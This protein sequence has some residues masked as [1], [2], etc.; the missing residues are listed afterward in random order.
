M[1]DILSAALSR[2]AG[3]VVEGPVRAIV[4]EILQDRGYASPAE[5][6]ALREELAELRQ[7]LEKLTS[8]VGDLRAEAQALR[9]QA[10][11]LAAAPPAAAPPARPSPATPARLG[12]SLEEYERWRQGGLPGRVGPDG[13]V[14]V[15]GQAFRVD[16]ALEGRPYSL[17]K[18]KVPRLLID[19]QPVE[20]SP[21]G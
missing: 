11:A 2:P 3:R 13:L 18:H 19:G 20:R 9:V 15:D 10:D 1:V 6:L 14:E 5:V 8:Q 17:S 16:P 4:T 21:V 12:M 7:A